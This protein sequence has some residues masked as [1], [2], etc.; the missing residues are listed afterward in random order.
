MNWRSSLFRFSYS[1]IVVALLH[2]PCVILI[3][4]TLLCSGHVMKAFPVA[5]S[6]LGQMCTLAQLLLQ[7]PFSAS[8]FGLPLLLVEVRQLLCNDRVR[9][10]LSLDKPLQQAGV[11]YHE[12]FQH[13]LHRCS[14]EWL[15][16][17]R[18]IQQCRNVVL[19]YVES[20]P[21]ITQV[22]S[23]DGVDEAALF[24]RD[25]CAFAKL[26]FSALLLFWCEVVRKNILDQ[27]FETIV[28]LC[29]S[30]VCCSTLGTMQG[31]PSA[32][33]DKAVL[34]RNALFIAVQNIPDFLVQQ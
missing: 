22:F 28:V 27:F 30:A 32:P 21:G 13:G 34:L 5:V 33:V 3:E 18:C 23:Q 26:V 6:E 31:D 15:S 19:E 24:R 2:F 25:G 14:L 4:D 11:P 20:D 12:L 17:Q 9:V 7:F 16:L 10:I 1:Y 8:S 29:S